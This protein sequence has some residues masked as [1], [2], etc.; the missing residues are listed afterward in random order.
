MKTMLQSI[1]LENVAAFETFEWNDLGSVNV[2][3]GENDT[4]K[5]YLLKLLYALSRSL[6]EYRLSQ[7]SERLPWDEVLARKLRWTFQP[8]EFKLGKIVR[9]GADRLEV[10]AVLDE[11]E[12]SFRFG[13]STTK[14]I[15]DATGVESLGD[16]LSALFFPPKE[17][18][19]AIDAIAASRDELKMPGFGDTYLDLIRALRRKGVPG[20]YKHP[21]GRVKD[22]LQVL[23][24]GEIRYE[25]GEFVFKRGNEHYNMSQTAEGVKKI[26]ILTQLIMNRSIDQG[27]IVFFD[28]PE[29]NLHPAASTALVKMLVLMASAGIQVFVATHDYFVLKQFELLAR[30]HELADIQLCSLERQEAGPVGYS[31]S[32]LGDG[33]PDNPIIDTSLE[34]LEQDMN[35]GMGS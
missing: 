23:F 33:M 21:L 5:T 2:V 20:K 1:E 4:G 29:A 27:S 34:L 11:E 18:L 31:I 25:E 10:R 12:Y 30:E 32:D 16:D 22:S 8:P 15:R 17:V 14:E 26:G 9:K 6:E 24:D 28:E 7:R 35:L 13:R 19:T 3:I